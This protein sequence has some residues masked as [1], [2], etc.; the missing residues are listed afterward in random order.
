MISFCLPNRLALMFGWLLQGDR[1]Q[2]RGQNS[3]TQAARQPQCGWQCNAH[4]VQLGR[5]GNRTL[6]TLTTPQYHTHLKMT[7]LKPWATRPA[8]L[9]G[10]PLF[11]HFQS[12][13]LRGNSA[14]VLRLT[15]VAS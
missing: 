4:A 12:S 15:S 9:L 6:Q 1:N 2:P 7:I 8:S 14:L 5:A 3:S 10:T 11:H 13:G